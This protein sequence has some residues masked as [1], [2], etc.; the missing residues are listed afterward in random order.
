MTVTKV[1][2][3]YAQLKFDKENETEGI[4]VKLDMGTNDIISS[5]SNC[6]VGTFYKTKEDYELDNKKKKLASKI[7]R[8]V[9]SFNGYKR[10][11]EATIG[12]LET[13]AR[14]LNVDLTQP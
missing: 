3:K 7:N 12:D 10:L 14:I 9:S 6:I 8:A 13:I 1:G 11:V 5:P 4:I 2:R